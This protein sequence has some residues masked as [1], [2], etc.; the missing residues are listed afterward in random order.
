M[1]RRDL[2]NV[3]TTG[4]RCRDALPCAN[5]ALKVPRYFYLLME[6]RL[7]RYF[8]VRSPTIWW[9]SATRKH[10]FPI[11][12]VTGLAWESQKKISITTNHI[13]HQRSSPQASLN[14]CNSKAWFSFNQP[15]RKRLGAKLVDVKNLPHKAFLSWHH[16]YKGGQPRLKKQLLHMR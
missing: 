2:R 14:Q 3:H 5:M 12:K 4:N 1:T 15:N 9:H 10:L 6:K 7:G 13:Y 11:L 8:Q 16:H